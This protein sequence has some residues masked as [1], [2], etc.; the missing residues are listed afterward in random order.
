MGSQ[1]G[2]LVRMA[3][4]RCSC[5]LSLND[6]TERKRGAARKNLTSIGIV[7]MGVSSLCYD[8]FQ[9]VIRTIGTITG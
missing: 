5:H 1:E 3:A 8:F 9:D 2:G 7:G 4:G 6:N